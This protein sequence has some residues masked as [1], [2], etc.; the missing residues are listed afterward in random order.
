[1]TQTTQTPRSKIEHA[2]QVISAPTGSYDKSTVETARV[3]LLSALKYGRK[4]VQS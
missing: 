2:L 3:I 4:A 1:M